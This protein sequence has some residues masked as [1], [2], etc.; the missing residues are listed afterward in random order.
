MDTAILF[1]DLNVNAFVPY[2]NAVYSYN[3][4][5]SGISLWRSDKAL[6]KR[7]EN[8]HGNGAGPLAGKNEILVFH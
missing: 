8:L 7:G 3:F 2:K 4:I 5:S 1:D 6:E